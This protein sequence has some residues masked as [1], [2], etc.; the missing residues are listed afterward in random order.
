VSLSL[1]SATGLDLALDG[2]MVAEKLK[3]A[4]SAESL[5]EIVDRVMLK[6]W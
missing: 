5:Q 1:E 6:K 2:M 3:R 4:Q